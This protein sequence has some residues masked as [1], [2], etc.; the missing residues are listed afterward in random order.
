MAAEYRAKFPAK[1]LIC[2]F[3]TA[4]W[5]WVCGGGSMPRWPKTTDSR[6]LAAIPKMQ[7]WAEASKD[8][9]W[10]LREAGKQ[11]LI[12]LGGNAELD[13]SN[14]SGS[15][16]M[17]MVNPRTGEVKPGEVV[18]AGGKVKLSN[19]VVVWFTKE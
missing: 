6:L 4:G 10:A 12:Y 16:R 15:F 7:P 19:A 17:N 1:P 9:R 3:D 18:K 11:M 5:A 8:G 14:E 2:D 13:L